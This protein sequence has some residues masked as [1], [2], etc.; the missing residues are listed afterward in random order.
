MQNELDVA[1]AQVASLHHQQQQDNAAAGGPMHARRPET[2]NIDISKF[3]AVDGE[4]SMRWFVEL[5]DAIEGRRITDD[6]MKRGVW[7]VHLA[8]SAKA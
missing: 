1:R 6:A 8:G 5:S 4:S 2:L 3:K 7:H